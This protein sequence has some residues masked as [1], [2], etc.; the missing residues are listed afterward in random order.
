MKK[1]LIP[2]LLLPLAFTSCKKHQIKKQTKQVAGTFRGQRELY[3]EESHTEKSAFI[4]DT[5][6][7]LVNE[8]AITIEK[9]D[10]DQIFVSDGT[11]S[12]TLLKYAG[13]N[14]QSTIHNWGRYYDSEY[15]ILYYPSTDSLFI[16]ASS[17][18]SSGKPPWNATSENYYFK[19]KRVAD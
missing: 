6:Y 5:A 11:G 8:V 2:I 12:G 16:T 15:T 14:M 10:D 13:H 17:S 7:N 18:G 9:K 19:G 3:H 4:L 1:I